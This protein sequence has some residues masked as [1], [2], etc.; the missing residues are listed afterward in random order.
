MTAHPNGQWVKKYKGVQYRFGAWD[1]WRAALEDYTWRWPAI[2]SGLGDPKEQPAAVEAALVEGG[3]ADLHYVANAYLAIK[4]EQRDKGKIDPVH[5]GSMVREVRFLLDYKPPESAST[6]RHRKPSSIKP[7]EWAK[8][9]GHLEDHYGPDARKRMIA[10]YRSVAKF[11]QENGYCGQWSFGDALNLPDKGELRAARREKEKRRGPKLFPREQILPII[12]ELS[13]PLDAMFYLGINAGFTSADC[14]ELSLDALDLDKG[15]FDY[16]RVKTGVQRAGYLWPE[17]VKAIREALKI[18]PAVDADRFAEAVKKWKAA[19]PKEGKEAVRRWEAREP[20]WDRLLF[21]TRFGQPWSRSYEYSQE[22]GASMA[23]NCD[24][25]GPEFKK[26]LK[27]LDK[28]HPKKLG[29]YAFAREGISFGTARHTFFTAAKLI[30]PEAAQFIQGHADQSMGS[31]YDHL[32]AAK[33]HMLK[34]VCDGIRCL[35]RPVQANDG[36]AGNLRLVGAAD[37]GKAE[38]V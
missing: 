23:C 29:G 19:K 10:L 16:D 25:I 21:L 8:F 5:Y 27:A 31:W 11:G 28:R 6:L 37:D 7:V 36:T 12:N 4:K 14:A 38:A 18:R 20:K 34:D 15:T 32:D 35:I 2:S 9:N 22:D 24:A 13:M 17:T 26:S 33:W 30:D 1:N 3:G